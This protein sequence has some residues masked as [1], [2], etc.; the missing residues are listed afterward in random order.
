MRGRPQRLLRTL[1]ASPRAEPQSRSLPLRRL[2]RASVG[3]SPSQAGPRPL[4]RPAGGPLARDP[5]SPAGL[6]SGPRGAEAQPLPGTVGS[7]P[8]YWQCSR[9]PRLPNRSRDTNNTAAPPGRPCPWP[10]PRVRVRATGR[11]ASSRRPE[12]RWL[13]S[14]HSRHGRKRCVRPLAPWQRDSARASRPANL[15]KVQTEARIGS[16]RVSWFDLCACAW[17]ASLLAVVQDQCFS[18]M[19]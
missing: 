11:A 6:G 17:Q 12:A 4:Q 10:S 1:V 8:G 18:K 3:I 2:D 16:R 5:P 13:P 9:T 19:A 7:G 15:G 14:R